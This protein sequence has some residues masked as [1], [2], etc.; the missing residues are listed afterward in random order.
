MSKRKAHKSPAAPLASHLEEIAQALRSRADAKNPARALSYQASIVVRREVTK[1]A[2]LAGVRRLVNH[3]A[4]FTRALVELDGRELTLLSQRRALASG[5]DILARWL[6]LAH[7]LPKLEPKAKKELPPLKRHKAI[8]RFK[9]NGNW[10]EDWGAEM[11]DR[12]LVAMTGDVKPGEVGYV[13]ITQFWGD[14]GERWSEYYNTFCFVCEVDETCMEWAGAK[15]NTCLRNYGK[16]CM[17]RHA[18]E[19]TN[20]EV[21]AFG[22]VCGVERDRRPLETTLE[23]RPYDEREG[24]PTT[25]IDGPVPRA[26][27]A[28]AEKP[29]VDADTARRLSELRARLKRLDEEDDQII[30]CTDRFKLETE[31]YDIEHPKEPD[32]NDWSAW[33][34]EGCEAGN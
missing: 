3:S 29:K 25:R 13:R 4:T 8:R 16:R 2:K 32:W 31:I 26:T 18:G 17:G 22:R 5:I 34:E 14:G 19:G 10:L 23:L 24:G 12:L 1:L 27:S 20:T 15:G 33:E 21:Y 7:V 9:L 6:D 30:R 11:G 28:E